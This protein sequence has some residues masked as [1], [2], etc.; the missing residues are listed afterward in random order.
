MYTIHQLP[1]KKKKIHRLNRWSSQIPHGVLQLKERD[2]YF[3]VT[4]CENFTI[5]QKVKLK[6]DK[7]HFK[8]KITMSLLKRQLLISSVKKQSQ[9]QFG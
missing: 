7:T 4:I 6:K 2:L 1:Q 5:S 3:T 8:K 9:K